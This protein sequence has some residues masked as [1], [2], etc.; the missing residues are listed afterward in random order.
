MR[1]FSHLTFNNRLKIEQML[2]EGAK[3][4][5]IA[6]ALRVDPSTISRELKRGTYQHLN[7][8]LTTEERYSPDIAHQR[9][10]R[11]LS[12][13]G[14][15]VK[16]GHDHEYAGHIEKKILE[17]RYSPGAVLG[18]IEEEGLTFQTKV[19]KTTLY[20]YITN[21]VLGVTDKDLLRKKKK[22]KKQ[23]QKR[24]ARPP[25]GESIDNRPKEVDTR[26]TPG[27]WEMDCVE[28][29]KE[30]SQKTLLVLTER[31]TRWEILILMARKT[32]EC[33][34]AALDKLEERCGEAFKQIF[35]TITVDNGSEFSDFM[36]IA[37]S[38]LNP[39]EARTQVFF[40]HA[41]CSWERGSNE[42]QNTMV[43]RR[44]P[45][46]FDFDNTTEEEIKELERWINK[47]PRGIFKY[48]SAAKMFK[49]EFGDLISL[50]Y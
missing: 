46:G 24:A 21:G 26:E 44:Y 23:K 20:R 22:K 5:E 4:S 13:K 10:K 34:V 28:G 3:Q 45:K 18:E 27:H 11:N 32:M 33:V 43:R 25:R 9:Y 8:D 50:L 31:K 40:C 7:S 36:G 14:P 30:G 29:P 19:S 38:A 35:K 41:Y 1:H 17:E 12:E 39:E 48:K 2:K 6:R 16:I 42:N 15:E 37:R 47:Y 49:G